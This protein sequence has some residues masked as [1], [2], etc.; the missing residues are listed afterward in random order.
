[1]VSFSTCTILSRKECKKSDNGNNNNNAAAQHQKC[2]LLCLPAASSHRIHRK[3][4]SEFH[5]KP[6]PKKAKYPCTGIV[7]AVAV[8]VSPP[9]SSPPP[10][11][12]YNPAMNDARNMQ[13]TVASNIHNNKNGSLLYS[14]RAESNFDFSGI[15]G[16]SYLL[17]AMV[18]RS[19]CTSKYNMII[20]YQYFGIDKRFT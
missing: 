4:C 9:P 16:S 14:Y 7:D 3:K 10:S 20:T 12:V 17:C 8:V 15:F 5:P 6:P 13:V 1:M 18:V 19:L 2:R 11:P